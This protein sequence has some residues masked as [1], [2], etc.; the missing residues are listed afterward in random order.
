MALTPSFGTSGLT[1]EQR[2]LA[3]ARFHILRPFLE[4]GVPLASIAQQHDLNLRTVRRWA[5]SYRQHG[6]AGLCRPARADKSKR[7]M[8]P[9]LQHCIEGF[10]LRQPRLTAAAVHRQAAA[11]AAQLG[12]PVPSYRTVHRVIQQLDPAPPDLSSRGD[13]V[14]QRHLRPGPSPGGG[15]AECDLAGRPQRTGHLAYS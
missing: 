10:A 12:E 2:S 7:R 13:E 5:K 1:E 9:T 3:L 8:S 14:L 4:E 11:A 6:L 15:P